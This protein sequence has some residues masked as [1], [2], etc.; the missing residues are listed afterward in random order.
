MKLPDI[1]PSAPLAVR[2]ILFNRTLAEIQIGHSDSR[3]FKT[4]DEGDC[5]Y[6]KT[7]AASSAQSFAVEV[8]ILGWLNGKLPVPE[9]AAYQSDDI[10]E[11]LILTEVPGFNC[12][13]AMNILPPSRIV[14]LL[15]EGLRQFHELDLTGCPFDLRIAQKLITAQ[16]NVR[17]GLVDETDFD[18]ERQGASATSLLE[19][20]RQHCPSEDDLVFNHGDYCLPNI[21][22]QDNAISGF[23]DL[24]R[25]GI[26]DRYNDLA[27]ASRSIATNLGEPYA[28]LFFEVYGVKKVNIEKIDYYRMMDELF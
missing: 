14:E 15:A 12:V 5:L 23:I 4:I 19:A 13:E 26:A 2:Q 6:L 16:E 21:L 8:D 18:P 27:I 3:V 17:L 24:G 10:Q 11:Y 9:A 7:Q 28:D 25:A 20:L 1:Y 22:I